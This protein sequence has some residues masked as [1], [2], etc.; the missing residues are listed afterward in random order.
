[1]GRLVVT[2][3]TEGGPESGLVLVLD[4]G[5]EILIRLLP[6]RNRVVRVAITAPDDVTIYREDS[7]D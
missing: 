7:N 6:R 4:D 5:R 2:R 3:K 1:M